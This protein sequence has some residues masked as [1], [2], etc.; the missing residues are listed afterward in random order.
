MVAS[1]RPEATTM[2]VATS[3]SVVDV[4]AGPAAMRGVCVAAAAQPASVR[5]RFTVCPFK[6]VVDYIVRPRR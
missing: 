6:G 4:E 2:K 3:P 5:L 1:V